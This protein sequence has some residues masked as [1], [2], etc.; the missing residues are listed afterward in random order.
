MAWLATKSDELSLGSLRPVLNV[1]EIRHH[2][3][4]GADVTA[5]PSDYDLIT[6]V[7]EWLKQSSEGG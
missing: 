6:A 7:D 1:D 3:T 5:V 4:R 2:V